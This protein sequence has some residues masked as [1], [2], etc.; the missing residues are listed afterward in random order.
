MSLIEAHGV[1]KIFA[2]W[3]DVEHNGSEVNGLTEAVVYYMVMIW[4][5]KGRQC[6]VL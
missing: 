1:D 2:G 6:R 5:G 3:K 4:R